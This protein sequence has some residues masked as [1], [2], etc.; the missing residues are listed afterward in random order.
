MIGGVVGDYI[1]SEFEHKTLRTYNLLQLTS[2]KSCI[3]DES[4]ML[5]ATAD[6]LINQ[7]DYS[8]FTE[9]YMRWGQHYYNKVDFGPGTSFWLEQG[10]LDYCHESKGN[11]AAT[12]AGIIGMLDHLELW[13]LLKLAEESARCSH[14]SIEAIN[15]AKAMV[16]TVW[17]ARYGRS[18]TEIYEYLHSEFDYLM[19]YNYEQL[20][21]ELTF[22]SSAEITVPVAIFLALESDSWQDTVRKVLYCAGGGDTD[23]IA[24][25]SSLISSQYYPIDQKYINET[26]FW[27]FQHAQPV[28]QMC[29]EF[30][31]KRA[32][33]QLPF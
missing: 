20:K 6:Y 27:L 24:S 30:E 25:M 29:Q 13:Q 1:G 12:R 19:Y 31:A 33:C 10:D 18:K 7:H 22:D 5:A 23:S 32:F 4:V 9:A 15:G 17:A 28:L 26:K 8:S 14:N 3:T 21:N 2:A 11:G 16:Y